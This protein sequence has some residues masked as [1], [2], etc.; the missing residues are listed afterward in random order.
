MSKISIIIPTYNN[1]QFIQK[2][3]DSVLNQSYTNCEII[4]VDDGS[5]DNTKDL[6]EDNYTSFVRYFYQANQGPGSARNLGLRYSE[7]EFVVFLD[8]DDYLSNY[9]L[10]VKF[11]AL[12]ENSDID[13]V[14]SDVYFIDENHE[15]LTLGSYHFREIYH[16]TSLTTENIFQLLLTYGNFITTSTLMIRKSCLDSIGFFDE[17]QLLHQDYLQWLS[18]S[19]KYS[20]YNYIS[21]PLV[22]KMQHP[23]SWGMNTKKSFEQRI[24]LYEKIERMY[25]SELKPA[26]KQWRRRFADAYNNLATIEAASGN[27]KLARLYLLK[28]IKKCTS[29]KF[30]Y[31]H[32]LQSFKK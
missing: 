10:M 16:N 32:F 22:Y 14:F 15:I 8:A 6:I 24:Q 5:T 31:Y 18:L 9:N 17:T 3:I 20:N 7:G 12:R 28:S 4:V 29:Q 26:F 1:S 13:W 21:K 30:A 19:H 25:Y 27:K 2:A 11:E 23:N